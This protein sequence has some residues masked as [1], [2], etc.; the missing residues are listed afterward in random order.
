MHWQV[1]AALGIFLCTQ[2]AI[3][4]LDL[5]SVVERSQ[6]SGVV[7]LGEKGEE[8]TPIQSSGCIVSAGGLILT[9]THQVRNVANLQGHF[10]DGTRQA[11]TVVAIDNQQEIALLK[12]EAPAGKPAQIGD[13][14]TLKSGSE[15]IAIAAPANLNFSTV[16]GIVSSTQRT[17]QGYSVLQTNLPASPGSSGGPVFNKDGDLVGLI[18]G[19]LR[20]QDWVTIVNPINN[21]RSLLTQHGLLPP[22]DPTQAQNANEAIIPSETLDIREKEAVNAY[23]T[24]VAAENPTQK[25]AAYESATHLLPAFYEA[26]FNLAIAHTSAGNLTEAWEAY[27]KARS[28]RPNAI[29]VHRNMGRIALK[30]QQTN[31]AIAC[32]QNALKYAPDDASVYNDLG[33]ALRQAKQ[34]DKAEQA[35]LKAQQLRHDYALAYYNLGLTY[36]AMDRNAEANV[37][38]KQYLKYAPSAPDA[39][40]INDLIAQLNHE[41]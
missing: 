31:D 35:L 8:K 28:L 17:Y 19:K 12:S 7:I 29:A 21:A 2:M 14:A 5:E 11:L 16:S 23:N 26:W 34:L 13:S 6:A 3:G 24:G 25:I 15:L 10:I 4:A 30:R 38:F 36:V 1:Q 40:A 18:I 41:N 32:F 27:A 22:V 39:S 20:D 33:E 9:T 37:Q